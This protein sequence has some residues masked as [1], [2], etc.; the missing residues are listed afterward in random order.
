MCLVEHYSIRLLRHCA[1]SPKVAGSR[2]NEVHEFFL[3]VYLILKSEIRL[4]LF[5]LKHKWVPE[6]DK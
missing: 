3:S 5:S 4:G 6:T 1:T 2:P